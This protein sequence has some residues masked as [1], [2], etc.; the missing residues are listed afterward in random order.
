[1]PTSSNHKRDV[2]RHSSSS[3]LVLVLQQQQYDSDSDA[4]GEVSGSGAAEVDG[5]HHRR[6]SARGSKEHRRLHPSMRPTSTEEPI[7][8]GLET[9]HG[10]NAGS[11]PQ[12]QWIPSPS[13]L[14]QPSC[15]AHPSPRVVTAASSLS[16]APA[17]TYAVVASNGKRLPK[18]RTSFSHR[19]SLASR[20]A[21]SL[22][23]QPGV[24]EVSPQEQQQQQQQQK[25]NSSTRAATTTR[26][27]SREQPLLRTSVKANLVSSYSARS[28]ETHRSCSA[29]KKQPH[30]P[31]GSKLSS[32]HA[33][34][35][36]AERRTSSGTSATARA[37][38]SPIRSP[39]PSQHRHQPQYLFL[40]LPSSPVRSPMQDADQQRFV[41]C[42]PHDLL[43]LHQVEQGT[44][45]TTDEADSSGEGVHQTS[46]GTAD[47]R[48]S[49]TPGAP[50]PHGS[51]YSGGVVQL[52]PLSVL[53]STPNATNVSS[54]QCST[55]LSPITRRPASSF[56][57]TEVLP[58]LFLGAYSDAMDT[59]ALAAHD[60]SLVVNCSEECEVTPAM[61]AN[62]HHVRYLQCPL[63][64]HSDQVI[65]P[66]FA[67]ISQVIHDQL[68]RRQLALQ[69]SSR[70]HGR[71]CR[72]ASDGETMR[73]S[74]QMATPLVQVFGERRE[75]RDTSGSG[76]QWIWADEADHTLDILAGGSPSPCLSSVGGQP[77]LK[78]GKR[79]TPNS[80]TSSSR[81]CTGGGVTTAFSE[82]LPSSGQAS[83]LPSPLPGRTATFSNG[84]PNGSVVAI[85]P[86]D[87]GGVLVHCRMGVSRSASLVMAYLILYG[88][89][90]AE[91]SSDAAAFL[92]DFM[93]KERVAMEEVG[94]WACNGSKN[95]SSSGGANGHGTLLG[96]ATFGSSSMAHRS[97]SI[98]SQS[99][100]GIYASAIEN[101]ARHCPPCALRRRRPRL[102]RCPADASSSGCSA[103]P[104][105]PFPVMASVS[106]S[107]TQGHAMPQ[108]GEE[109]TAG[110][111][112]GGG[113]GGGPCDSL[114]MVSSRTM[115]SPTVTTEESAG[116]AEGPHSAT[117]TFSPTQALSPL[118]P[119]QLVSLSN[120]SNG[121]GGAMETMTTPVI[122]PAVTQRQGAEMMRSVADGL[123]SDGSFALSTSYS[124][125]RATAL[126]RFSN[127]EANISCGS[128]SGGQPA[129]TYREAFD[130]V[131]RRKTDVNPNIGFVLALRELAGGG[132][133]SFSTTLT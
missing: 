67:P 37:V 16:T 116:A 119:S 32:H 3:K 113:R 130:T 10:N 40:Q 93:S 129:M 108:A 118:N 31:N 80:P 99:S 89:T 104:A 34:G 46:H 71:L 54:L 66:Y 79:E 84:S 11:S 61:A 83:L 98:T 85:D 44:S 43:K 27:N 29:Q 117:T 132:E 42:T 94:G 122:T 20:L 78:E 70:A 28:A 86:R 49:A 23:G 92:L 41:A 68:H 64:D 2:G 33:N 22:T 81:G 133:F 9:T 114:T 60:I 58:G 15:L 131:K 121:H 73:Q 90:L 111:K 38:S 36:R 26:T 123:Q 69:R 112:M 51:G 91:V 52:E 21:S 107:P 4:M 18:S 76:Q 8:K 115:A 74:S 56:N 105:S 100:P 87:C 14:S 126:L 53:A 97:A 127:T 125:M 72:C 120:A 55:A 59:E 62:G 88:S 101:A 82:G 102:A 45:C 7:A 110:K 6:P 124:A 39:L 17:L 106:S 5:G 65:A 48:V 12:R 96:A 128:L 19:Y 25:R 1:M 24:T 35:D 103:S 13:F 57:A 30:E 95:V 77:S 47:P 75:G 63:K 109:V 50:E